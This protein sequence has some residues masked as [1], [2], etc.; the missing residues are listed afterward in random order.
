D[1]LRDEEEDLSFL[2]KYKDKIPGKVLKEGKPFNLSK[3]LK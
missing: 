3:E 2:R 1:E